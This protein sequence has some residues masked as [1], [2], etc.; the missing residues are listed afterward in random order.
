[1]DGWER[2]GSIPIPAASFVGEEMALCLSCQHCPRARGFS[3]S[4]ISLYISERGEKDK[5]DVYFKSAYKQKYLCSKSYLLSPATPSALL[6]S[7]Y[8][9]DF[10]SWKTKWNPTAGFSLPQPECLQSHKWTRQTL[11]SAAL[12]KSVWRC[13][14]FLGKLENENEKHLKLAKIT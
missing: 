5:D 6:S 8:Q 7:F 12:E 3:F 4:F 9:T 14:Y 11:L 2:R 13:L 1:M 10:N